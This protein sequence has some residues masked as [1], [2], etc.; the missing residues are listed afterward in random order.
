MRMMLIWVDSFRM[1]A[2]NAFHCGSGRSD[3]G[4]HCSAGSPRR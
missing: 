1:L 4:S 3:G 2:T